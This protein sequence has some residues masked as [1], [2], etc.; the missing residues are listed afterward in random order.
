[1]RPWL[2]ICAVTLAACGGGPDSADP[3]APGVWANRKTIAFE[4]EKRAT[5]TVRDGRGELLRQQ[6]VLP[7][8]ALFVPGLAP[9]TT[10][11]LTIDDGRARRILGAVTAAKPPEGYTDRSSARPGDTL[12]LFLS[13]PLTT[14]TVELVPALHPETALASWSFGDVPDAFFPRVCPSNGCDWPRMGTITLPVVPSGYYLLRF[15]NAAGKSEYPLVVKPAVPGGHRLAVIAATNTWQAYNP[16]GGA[17]Y[18]HNELHGPLLK[19][20]SFRRP[21]HR[22]VVTGTHLL[23]G[24]LHLARWLE[25]QGIAYDLYADEDVDAGALGGA[26]DTWIFHVHSEY[27]TDAMLARYLAHVRGG[28]RAVF[29]SGDVMA[30]AVGYEEGGRMAK[31]RE[32]ENRAGARYSGSTYTG[33]DYGTYAGYEVLQPS[34]WAFEGTGLGLRATFGE[35]GAFGGASG[36]ET[37]KIPAGAK[38]RTLIAKGTNPGGGADMFTYALGKGEVFHVGSVTFT[39]ALAGDKHVSRIVR[40]VI[41]RY[42][43]Q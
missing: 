14:V 42:N 24:E 27:W 18:Y 38:G 16:W 3:L 8:Q 34:H 9:S 37:D 12:P 13:S 25:A 35:A 31:L 19:W 5:V 29:L 22:G 28:G 39:G 23:G 32:H 30:W 20:V 33:G 17:S 6:A 15:S 7:G 40:N 10:Y 26:Y 43:G 11:T 41:R 36:H 21:Y 4:S 1:M 2:L